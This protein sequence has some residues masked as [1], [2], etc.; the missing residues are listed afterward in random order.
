MQQ[1]MHEQKKHASQTKHCLK[2]DLCQC[3]HVIN[4][5]KSLTSHSRMLSVGTKFLRPILWSH[6][7]LL[8][9]LPQRGMENAIFPSSARA[10]HTIARHAANVQFKH[11]IPASTQARDTQA[12]LF[13]NSATEA[14]EELSAY[15]N[16]PNPRT[17]TQ[18]SVHSARTVTTA[19]PFEQDAKAKRS[20]VGNRPIA[21]LGGQIKTFRYFVKIEGL[22]KSGRSRALHSRGRHCTLLVMKQNA[23]NRSRILYL[24]QAQVTGSVSSNSA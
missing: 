23:L 17:K 7:F 15:R 19:A 9:I 1:Y 16:R 20:R 18:T 12:L 22:Y 8:L 10:R 24:H 4:I 2:L 21:G 11:I 5:A 13:Y 14:R 6:T 3:L